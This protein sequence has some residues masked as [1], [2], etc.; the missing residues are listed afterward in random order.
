MNQRTKGPEAHRILK[1]CQMLTKVKLA[2][3]GVNRHIAQNRAQNHVASLQEFIYGYYGCPLQE[4]LLKDHI[5]LTIDYILG[6]A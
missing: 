6:V 4:K 3:V 1:I 5:S 2:K